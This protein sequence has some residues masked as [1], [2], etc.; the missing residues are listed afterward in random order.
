MQML[1]KQVMRLRHFKS[2]AKQYTE[3]NFKTTTAPHTPSPKRSDYEQRALTKDD[4]MSKCTYINPHD[5]KRCKNLLGMYPKFCELHTIMIYNVFIGKSNIT[6]AGN[7]LFAGPHGFKKGDVIGKYSFS[8]NNVTLGR[9]EERC[10]DDNC[11]SYVFCEEGDSEDTQCWDGL[12]IRSTLMRNIN[13]AHN[14]RFK[15][16][17]YF[18]VIKDQ[19]YVIASRNIKPYKEIFVDYGR[20][21]WN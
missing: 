9:L 18:D 14:S 6:K 7:G 21:Y 19:V 11:W 8:W 5:G 3:G 13:D 10:S 4:G 16:N 17:C 1:N 15:N 12:D 2:P 20:N